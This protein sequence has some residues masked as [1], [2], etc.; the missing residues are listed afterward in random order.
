MNTGN[1]RLGY[2]L[3]GHHQPTTLGEQTLHHHHYI[4]ITTIITIPQGEREG[5]GREKRMNECQ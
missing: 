2:T 3:D 5:R 1:H 4:I